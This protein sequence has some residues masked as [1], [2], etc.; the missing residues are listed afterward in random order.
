[1]A[2]VVG[3]RTLTAKTRFDTKSAPVRGGVHKE[4]RGRFFC[5][6][7][8]FILSVLIFHVLFLFIYVII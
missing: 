6:H 8:G 3:R 5:K 1:M 4:T 7:I 2:H